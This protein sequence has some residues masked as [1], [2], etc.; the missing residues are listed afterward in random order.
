[1]EGTFH[2]ADDSHGCCLAEIMFARNLSSVPTSHMEP[3]DG[4][5]QLLC[6]AVTSDAGLERIISYRLLLPSFSSKAVMSN[7]KCRHEASH[8]TQINK[9]R[10]RSRLT[11]LWT[12]TWDQIIYCEMVANENN[13]GS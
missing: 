10:N 6:R 5:F 9:Q 11:K 1:M 8:S 12:V 7:T 4:G 2:V 3:D 13:L